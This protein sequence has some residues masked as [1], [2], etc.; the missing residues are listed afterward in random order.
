MKII[1]ALIK[2]ILNII[3]LPYKIYLHQFDCDYDDIFETNKKKM[4]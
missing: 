2:I 4:P 3:F 1:K